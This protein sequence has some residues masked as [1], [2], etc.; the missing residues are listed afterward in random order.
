MKP[1]SLAGSA[2]ALALG[3]ALLGGSA[4]L[5]LA[6]QLNVFAYLEGGNVVVEAKFS[7]GR[8][9]QT[10][11]VQVFDGNEALVHEAALGE[12]GMAR[13]PVPA[14]DTGLKVEVVASEGHSN[15][16]ILTPQDLAAAGEPEA[17]VAP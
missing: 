16:W 5:A 2:R 17:G 1:I 14:S 7:T 3:L 13:F 9:A 8:V 10:G 6:H 15:Y 4:G 11:T 12:D